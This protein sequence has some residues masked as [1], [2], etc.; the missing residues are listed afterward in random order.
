MTGS[1]RLERP[2]RLLVISAHPCEADLAIGGSVA[3]WVAEG[4]VAHL[5]CGT[6]G[7]ASA[8][9]A[10]LDP[11]ELAARREAEQRAAASVLGYEDVTFLHR[12]EGALVNDLALRE[13]LVRVI[14]TVRP[15]AVASRDPRVIIA[16]GG[17]IRPVDQRET[18]AAAID[19][20]EP[21]AHAAM[22]FP[23]LVR[24]EGLAPH[25]VARIHLFGADLPD[26][27]VDVSD[28]IDTKLKALRCHGSQRV[29]SEGLEQQV[30][31][32]A[33]EAGEAIGVAA[34]EAFA[35][36]DLA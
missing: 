15:D 1:H 28:T 24:S 9:D 13:Q 26:G 10:T 33:G 30:R 16:R 3:R 31:Q 8:D 18:A 27:W 36:I 14:R 29:R 22:A 21:A 35:V 25:R 12:P 6:S 2:T 23:H 34:A 7:E 17:V 19:A 5:V 32:W 20:L 11:L 4:T